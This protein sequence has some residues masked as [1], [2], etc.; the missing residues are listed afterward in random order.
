MDTT[1]RTFYGAG[2]ET[3]GKRG[4]FKEFRP[5][6]TRI[7]QA[8]VIHARGRPIST[9]MVPGNMTDRTALLPAVE[10]MRKCLG[11]TLACNR[12]RPV[13]WHL[14]RSE[15]SGNGPLSVVISYCIVRWLVFRNRHSSEST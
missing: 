2:G 4:H 13:T 9:G 11:I 7:I 6:P 1:S 14:A 10:R 3:L 5:E 12:L 15:S 8:L